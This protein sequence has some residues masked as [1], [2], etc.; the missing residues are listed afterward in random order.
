[1]RNGFRRAVAIITLAGLM[2]LLPS[3]AILHASEPVT[4]ADWLRQIFVTPD[5]KVDRFQPALAAA[6]PPPPPV[7]LQT[8]SEKTP[9]SQAVN[10]SALPEA[11]MR[12]SARRSRKRRARG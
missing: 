12:Q 6:S 8:S 5:R 1:V 2:G 9:P 11:W 7:V 4:L 10:R 3:A